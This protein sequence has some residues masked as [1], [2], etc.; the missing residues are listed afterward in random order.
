MVKKPTLTI[1]EFARMGARA[2]RKKY[3]KRKLRA[4][5]KLGGRPK[6]G[7]ARRRNHTQNQAGQLHLHQEKEVAGF[8]RCFDSTNLIVTSLA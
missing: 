2:L 8:A 5:A 6:K 7:A 4:W 1:K 3:S